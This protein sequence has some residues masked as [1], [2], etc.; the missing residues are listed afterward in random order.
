MLEETSPRLLLVM[1]QNI[2]QMILS[3]FCNLISLSFSLSLSLSACVCVCVR[4]STYNEKDNFFPQHCIFLIL[5]NDNGIILAL[6]PWVSRTVCASFH[7]YVRF[8]TKIV[9]RLRLTHLC[10]ADH[11]TPYFFPNNWKWRK[12]T[13]STW[14]SCR[15][16]NTLKN[17]IECLENSNCFW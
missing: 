3:S 14:A 2:P 9:K 7:W 6:P 17:C 5:V 8:M 1:C 15:N 10:Q 16:N 13:P 12:L 4:I 11:M